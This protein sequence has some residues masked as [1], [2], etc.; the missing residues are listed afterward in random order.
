MSN[1]DDE[2]NSG[3]LPEP[4]NWALL[5]STVPHSEKGYTSTARLSVEKIDLIDYYIKIGIYPSRSRFVFE[6]IRDAYMSLIT[7][8]SLLSPEI[9]LR[10][11]S[12]VQVKDAMLVALKKIHLEKTGYTGA[13]E[14]KPTEIIGVT[15]D[16]AFLQ[17][18]SN[19]LRGCLSLDGF[20]GVVSY[21]TYIKLK[22]L[23]QFDDIMG[24]VMSG[25]LCLFDDMI[26][27]LSDE[28]YDDIFKKVGID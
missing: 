19:T 13:P 10:C 28:D 20:Q 2:I 3:H 14:K 17:E 15:G 24:K 22:E 4:I 9:N 21:C 5:R 25:D 7:N 26:H 27:S 16:K 23:G 12:Q 8:M 1:S 18:S 6:A 11:E